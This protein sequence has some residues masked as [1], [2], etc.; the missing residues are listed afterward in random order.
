MIR[1]IR[2]LWCGLFHGH[3]YTNNPIEE[4]TFC[5]VYNY[6]KHCGKDAY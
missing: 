3:E 6:C 1:F 2:E 5:D 4:G